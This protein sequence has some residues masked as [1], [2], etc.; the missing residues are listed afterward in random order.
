MLT[1]R[2]AT[3]RDAQ[4]LFEWRN[5]PH[6]R[7]M[8]KTTDPVT[9]DTHVAWLNNRLG[10][11]EPHL[12]VAKDASGNPVGTI[13][14]DEDSTSDESTV[15]Y[16]VAPQSRKRGYATQMLQWAYNNFGSLVAEIK[17]GN[18]ASVRAA[19]K[20]GHKVVFLSN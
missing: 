19:P 13:R 11:S 5:D 1:L 2:P 20:A 4:V 7:D 16:T 9:W 15:G 3:V 6:T 18:E 8:S 10:L 12:Y 14:I 17:P